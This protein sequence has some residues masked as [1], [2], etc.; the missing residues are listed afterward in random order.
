[1]GERPTRVALVEIPT[2]VPTT[3]STRTKAKSLAG[4][5]APT[6]VQNTRQ[7]E[8]NVLPPSVRRRHVIK[9]ALLQL[10]GAIPWPG[11]VDT[12]NF[13]RY[14]TENTLRAQ[15][16]DD[17]AFHAVQKPEVVVSVQGT[18]AV[19]GRFVCDVTVSYIVDRTVPLA[20]LPGD[21]DVWR[22]VVAALG[23]GDG[24]YAAVLRRWPEFA[25]IDGATLYLTW[26]AGAA[27]EA[28]PAS[29]AYGN[30]TAVGAVGMVALVL[31]AV[32]TRRRRWCNSSVLA[33][34]SVS[35][36]DDDGDKCGD[37][38]ISEISEITFACDEES[39]RSMIK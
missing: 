24:G 13:L 38:E 8:P 22:V 34:E 29:R 20:N 25:G 1:L 11:D 35:E 33:E 21:S 32:A 10:T 19:A 17:A 28:A 9:N 4:A 26:A 6:P 30:G 18:R 37:D 2:R 5:S 23:G 27:E 39:L 31:V 15:V 14:A 12:T 3:I 7:A 16:R 36:D